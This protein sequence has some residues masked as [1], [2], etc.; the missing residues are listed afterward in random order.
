MAEGSVRLTRTITDFGGRKKPTNLAIQG[1]RCLAPSAAVRYC[2]AHKDRH[3][4]R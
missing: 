1:A 4:D 2:P 3:K